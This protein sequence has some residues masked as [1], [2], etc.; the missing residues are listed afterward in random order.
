MFESAYFD[1]RIALCCASLIVAFFWKPPFARAAL[2][3]YFLVNAI[4]HGMPA[5]LGSAAW[6][7]EVSLPVRGIQFAAA[8]AVTSALY[9]GITKGLDKWERMFLALHAVA[10]GLTAA[11]IGATWMPREPFQ[12]IDA[13]RQW[14]YFAM[15]VAWSASW[16]WLRWKRPLEMPRGVSDLGNAW[17]W[18][19]WLQFL[20]STTGKGNI[21]WNLVSWKG[22]ADWYY[23]V[24]DL[25]M[26]GHVGTALWIVAS[27]LHVRLPAVSAIWTPASGR[28][29][30]S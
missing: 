3:L 20:I 15:A 19:M 18:W 13:S 21:L 1:L 6:W 30:L 28:D 23:G 29:V 27:S 4:E 9:W 24:S 26:L 12:S 17:H 11:L 10:L 8:I 2:V 14:A 7:R 25:S 5:H 22:G 16:L